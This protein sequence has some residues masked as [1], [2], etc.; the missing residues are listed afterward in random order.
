MN[1]APSNASA[2]SSKLN[3]QTEMK[4]NTIRIAS[5]TVKISAVIT[6]SAAY[7]SLLPPSWAGFAAIAFGIVSIIKDTALAAGDLADDGK[8]NNSF[9][10]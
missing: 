5:A 10:P 3:P 9:K 7:L 1:A 4:T 8:R 2:L 6:G